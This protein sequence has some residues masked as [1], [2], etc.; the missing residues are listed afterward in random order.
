MIR[1]DMVRIGVASKQ[2]SRSLRIPPPVA[3]RPLLAQQYRQRAVLTCFGSY[4]KRK[5][6]PHCPSYHHLRGL[7]LAD[8]E[9]GNDRRDSPSDHLSWERP[10]EICQAKVARTSTIFVAFRRNMTDLR[11]HRPARGRRLAWL[12]Y[13][14]QRPEQR[15][16]TVKISRQLAKR[17]PESILTNLGCFQNKGSKNGS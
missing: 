9:P 1:V 15:T 13:A 10:D 6:P 17:R 4:P 2:R 14:S 7:K 12:N 3:G 8:N 16:S 5:L 11:G